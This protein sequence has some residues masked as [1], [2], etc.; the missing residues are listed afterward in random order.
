MKHTVRS[1]AE[2]AGVSPATVSRVLN[3]SGAVSPEKRELVSRLL[4][5]A[6]SGAPRRRKRT[7]GGTVGV[8]L[9]PGCESDPHVVL[10][11]LNTA[12]VR[13]PRKWS[14]L[15]L[16][17][18]SL[19]G[20][21]SARYLRGDLAGLLL[22]GHRV[23]DQ[24]FEAMLSHLPHVWLNSYH[25]SGGQVSVLMGN[26]FAGRI[27]AR[28][29]QSLKCRRIVCLDV[30]SANPGFRARLDGFRFELFARNASCSMISLSLPGE[31]KLENCSAELLEQAFEA[32]GIM[33]KLEKADGIF[34]P[35]DRLTAFLHRALT[36]RKIRR[37]PEIVSCNRTEEYLA[38]L[39]PRPASI[40]MGAET[41][42]G[43]GL[44]ELFR[45][46]SGK[47]EMDDDVA[48]IAAPRL[49][50]GDPVFPVRKREKKAE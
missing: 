33:K 41:G 10:K 7:N 18:E 14:L 46:I 15:L 19:P 22:L 29:L 13:L 49:V 39:Y 35:E 26:E 42:A 17:P 37:F 28:H 31:E 1:I 12:I 36:I 9:L 30:P 47:K 5:E 48:V 3:G 24:E 32:E 23:P 45:R 25:V 16:S 6:R 50:K 38:G 2:Q 40:D 34:S 21:L 4:E 8:V 43:L 44:E 11:K 20:E 27:A